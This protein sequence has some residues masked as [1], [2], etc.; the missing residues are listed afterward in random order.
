MSEMQ[1]FHNSLFTPSDATDARR[2]HLAQLT[3][4]QR[5]H[6]VTATSQ[7]TWYIWSEERDIKPTR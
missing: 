2:K 1:T 4:A 5:T 3:Q 6:L 7:Q